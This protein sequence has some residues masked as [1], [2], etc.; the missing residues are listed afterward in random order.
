MSSFIIVF[1]VIIFVIGILGVMS[2]IHDTLLFK[3]MGKPYIESWKTDNDDIIF[4]IQRRPNLFQNILRSI[5]FL[6]RSHCNRFITA[7]EINDWDWNFNVNSPPNVIIRKKKLSLK[8]WKTVNSK[9]MANTDYSVLYRINNE[10]EAL[11]LLEDEII[12]WMTCVGGLHVPR[13]DSTFL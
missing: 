2:I 5:I 1:L 9:S 13:R 11:I 4:V 10:V 8:N 3:N 6:G 7:L 12:P